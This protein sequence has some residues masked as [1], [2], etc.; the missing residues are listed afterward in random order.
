MIHGVACSS[1]VKVLCTKN[2]FQEI[3][4]PTFYYFYICS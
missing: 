3:L 4:V 1:D 2:Y